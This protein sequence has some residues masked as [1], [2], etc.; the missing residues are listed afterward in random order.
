MLPHSER[1]W[2]ME[3]DCV[4]HE[5]ACDAEGTMPVPKHRAASSSAQRLK[6]VIRSSKEKAAAFWSLVDSCHFKNSRIHI[7]HL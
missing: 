7:L 2:L 5:V 1:A 4:R 3:E 6:G